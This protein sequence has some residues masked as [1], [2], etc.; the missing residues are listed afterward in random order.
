MVETRDFFLFKD[1]LNSF[2][3]EMILFS[4]TSRVISRSLEMLLLYEHHIIFIRIH[5]RP[6]TYFTNLSSSQVFIQVSRSLHS[7]V[8]FWLNYDE[9]ALNTYIM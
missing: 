3:I 9:I 2:E 7:R 4:V 5:G 6:S 8:T 1:T